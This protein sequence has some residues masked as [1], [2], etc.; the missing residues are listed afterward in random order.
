MQAFIAFNSIAL[1]HSGFAFGF[2]TNS[3]TCR[4]EAFLE[5]KSAWQLQ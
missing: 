3:L 5:M 2:M 4:F 1:S